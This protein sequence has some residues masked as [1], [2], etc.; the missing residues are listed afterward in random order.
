MNSN[1]LLIGIAGEHLACF[2]LIS[3]GYT[4]FMTDQGMPYDLIIEVDGRLLKVQVKTTRTHKAIPQRKNHHPAYMYHVRRCGKGGRGKYSAKDVDLFALVCVETKQ[5]GYIKH[6]KMPMT[7]SVRVDSFK[8]KYLNEVQE[9]RVESVFKLKSEGFA[10]A[11]IARMIE[12][13]PSVVG[14]VL[15]GKSKKTNEGVYFSDLT[16]EEA[17]K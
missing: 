8:G 16:I 5:V 2:D 4:T 15:A 7:M 11:A 14:R 9:K 3:K 13:D 12:M 10:N 6:C 1:D 17:L